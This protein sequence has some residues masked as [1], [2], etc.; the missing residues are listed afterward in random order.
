MDQQF[1]TMNNNTSKIYMYTA[2]IGFISTN[3]N[4]V[5]HRTSDGGASWNIISGENEF[6]DIKFA[7]CL[8]GW[9]ATGIM[10]KTTDGGLNWI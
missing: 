8:T 6:S 5:L 3:S 7:D 9:K 1:S 2:H 10:K 4:T